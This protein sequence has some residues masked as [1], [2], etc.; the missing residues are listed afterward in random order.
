MDDSE[1]RGAAPNLFT[2]VIRPL[3]NNARKVPAGS[4]RQGCFLEVP[5]DV[6]DIAGID[7]CRLHANKRFSLTRFWNCDFFDAQDGRRSKLRKP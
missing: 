4:S 5:R 7:P 6:P 3:R 2:F 1:R